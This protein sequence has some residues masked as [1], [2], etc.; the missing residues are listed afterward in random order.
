MRTNIKKE[1][2]LFKYQ[3]KDNYTNLEKGIVYGLF[4]GGAIGF[5]LYKANGYCITTN[6]TYMLAAPAIGLVAGIIIG[7][8]IPE[9]KTAAKKAVS[10]PKKKK[11]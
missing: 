10:K 1:G 11:K 7:G 8:S 5:L 4:F 2:K 3:S 6:V 9:G